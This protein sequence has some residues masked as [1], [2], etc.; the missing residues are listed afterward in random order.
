MA[1]P[2]YVV[3]LALGIMAYAK[4]KDTVAL[5]F[6]IAFGLFG[7][8]HFLNLINLATALTTALIIIR[9]VAY[10]I[11]IFALLKRWKP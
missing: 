8:S 3:I 10:L 7:V 5:Y 11:V 2:L 4:K 6:G 9:T 1:K